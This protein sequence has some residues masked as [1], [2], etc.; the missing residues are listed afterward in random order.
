MLNIFKYLSCE[1][2]R[3]E[4]KTIQFKFVKNIGAILQDRHANSVL[5][6]RCS[7]IILLSFFLQ[8]EVILKIPL[9]LALHSVTQK[10]SLGSFLVEG[11]RFHL[12][13][14]VS[15]QLLFSCV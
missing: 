5:N 11:T 4:I 12:I 1:A 7:E 8:V 15:G 2:F 3:I 10:M 13:F 14:L 6:M 9:N